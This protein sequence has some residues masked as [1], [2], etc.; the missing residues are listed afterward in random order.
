MTKFSLK[1]TVLHVQ[2]SVSTDVWSPFKTTILVRLQLTIN[3]DSNKPCEK[4]KLLSEDQDCQHPSLS[5]SLFK[6]IIFNTEQRVWKWSCASLLKLKPFIF[7]SQM[8]DLKTYKQH[9]ESKH[10]KA[11]LP[12][13]LKEQPAA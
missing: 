6:F 9:F 13:E 2:D 3:H 5:V 11:P 7:Q 1:S 4:E 12:E 10:S 8:N